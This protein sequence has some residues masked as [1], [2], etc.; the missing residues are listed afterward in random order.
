MTPRR[1]GRKENNPDFAEQ[2]VMRERK[3]PRETYVL[4][5]GDFTRPDKAAGQIAPAV[6]SAVGRGPLP[7]INRSRGSIWL[8]G[9][10]VQRIR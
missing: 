7:P 10:S 8:A 4:T 3:S 2:M 5:R 1:G 6:L 9:W